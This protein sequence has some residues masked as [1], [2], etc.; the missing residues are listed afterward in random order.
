M[1][2]VRQ[3]K[4]NKDDKFRV[5]NNVITQNPMEYEFPQIEEYFIYTPKQ[6]YPVGNASPNSGNNGIKIAKDAITYCTSGL[7]DRNKGIGL[8]YLHKAIKSLN[9][10]RMIEDSL[11][12]YRLCLLYTSD[13]ADE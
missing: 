12:I 5:S 9:Q 7:V 3:Q 1:R 4:K 10:L 6:T 8:S 2:Y 11:V 13:A